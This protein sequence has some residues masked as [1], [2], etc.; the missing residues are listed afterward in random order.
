MHTLGAKQ[1]NKYISDGKASVYRV[2]ARLLNLHSRPQNAIGRT[3]NT[4]PVSVFRTSEH[5][6]CWISSEPALPFFFWEA[7]RVPLSERILLSSIA[8]LLF[9]REVDA[10]KR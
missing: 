1:F 10:A 7:A 3:L 9:D 5:L 8:W 6:R 4:R 2:E